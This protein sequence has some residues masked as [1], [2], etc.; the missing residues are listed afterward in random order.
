MRNRT[1]IKPNSVWVPKV[2]EELSEE[3]W[4]SSVLPW[5]GDTS[6]PKETDAQTQLAA[7]HTYR[8]ETLG[9]LWCM[10]TFKKTTP[11]TGEMVAQQLKTP[12]AFP[13]D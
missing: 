9:W 12:A 13:E 11:G 8:S 5:K 4:S 1:F 3:Q 2:T 7:A 6:A 10:P